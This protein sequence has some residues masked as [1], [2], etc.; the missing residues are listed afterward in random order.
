MP[1]EFET[2]REMEAES[3]PGPE[4]RPHGD[5]S[6]M[7][8]YTRWELDRFRARDAVAA[9]TLCTLLLL[10]FA[11]GAV[12]DAADELDPGIGRDIVKAVGGPAGWVSDR[13]PLSEPRRDALAWLSPDEELS[14]GGFGAGGGQEGVEAAEV[15]E[16]GAELE[17]I[18][19]T[20][21]SLSTPLDNEVAQRIAD[22]GS[23]VR[24][25]RE[26]HLG[27]GIS[28]T[29]IVDWGALSGTQAESEA[30][31]AV[32]MFIGANEFYPMTT[33]AGMTVECCGDDWEAELQARIGQM[34]G[35]Y[36][37]E[38]DSRVYWLNLPTQ[39]DPDRLPVTQAVNRAIAEAA[40]EHG[41]A[42]RVIDMVPTFTPEGAY[43]DSIR[44]GG[45]DTIVRESD[46][47]HL[48]EDGAALAAEIVLE[49]IDRDFSR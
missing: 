16:Q 30:P 46:G 9:T 42:V 27:T 35:N 37:A 45:E 41:D 21:D 1:G 36:V 2:L 49:A 3:R 28:N 12:R 39:R 47:I 4:G 20:G 25:I 11:G 19:V 15:P 5:D 18:L 32:V 48:N 31:D 23:A 10:V 7:Q 38:G 6:L 24:V 29:D 44:I 8:R 26:P 40:A 43:T 13:L 17:T 34:M 33:A 22:E 14:G